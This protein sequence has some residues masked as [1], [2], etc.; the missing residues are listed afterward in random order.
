MNMLTIVV[1]CGDMIKNRRNKKKVGVDN[2][3]LNLDLIYE[4]PPRY[5]QN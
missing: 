5:L 4:A 3:G 1:A 2:S